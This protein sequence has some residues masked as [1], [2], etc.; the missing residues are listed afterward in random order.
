M[1]E[2]REIETGSGK[3]ELIIPTNYFHG[4]NASL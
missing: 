1:E 2:E 4:N 3:E